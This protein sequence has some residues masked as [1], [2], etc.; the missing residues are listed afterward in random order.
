MYCTKFVQ[1]K[2]F[3]VEQKQN[4]VPSPSQVGEGDGWAMGS[5]GKENVYSKYGSF[6]TA[7]PH[8]A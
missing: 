6:H 4:N 1:D 3:Y 8:N 5:H 7:G 2:T